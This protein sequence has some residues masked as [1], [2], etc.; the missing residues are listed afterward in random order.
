MKKNLKD[1]KK[2]KNYQ[3]EMKD[4]KGSQIIVKQEKKD[5]MN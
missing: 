2:I 1:L 4:Y 5:M 3:K